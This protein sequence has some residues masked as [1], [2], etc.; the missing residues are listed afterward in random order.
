MEE[1]ILTSLETPCVVLDYEK[2]EENIK[3]IQNKANQNNV[4]L[5]P[6]VKTH[7]CI[8]IAALQVSSC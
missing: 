8:E 7:K 1:E 3:L 5:R 4:S 6:H 2:L